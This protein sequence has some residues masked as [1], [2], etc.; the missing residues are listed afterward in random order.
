M[1]LKLAVRLILIATNNLL[2]FTN[3]ATDPYSNLS[4]TAALNTNQFTIDAIIGS[5]KLRHRTLVFHCSGR[6]SP[7]GPSVCPERGRPGERRV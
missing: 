6:A 3:S 7:R 4:D 1:R 5:A 2:V